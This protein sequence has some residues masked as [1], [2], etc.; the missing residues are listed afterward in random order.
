[1]DPDD[2]VDFD[3]ARIKGNMVENIKKYESQFIHGVPQHA[4]ISIILDVNGKT[5]TCMDGTTRAKAKQRAK[6]VKPSQKILV[7]TYHHVVEGFNRD[8]WDDFQDQANDHDGAQPAT[9]EDMQS[10]ILERVESGRLQ[11]V[12]QQLLGSSYPDTS[13]AEGLKTFA[14]QGGIWAK[15]TLFKN[16]SRTGL[17]FENRIF[18]AICE[19]ASGPTKM[20]TRTTEEALQFYSNY[21]DTNYVNTSGNV[22][23]VSAGEKVAEVVQSA[24]I[25][26]WSVG[27]L[28][29]YAANLGD[30]DGTFTLLLN[31]T[32]TE[33]KGLDAKKLDRKREE[34]TKVFLTRRKL[35]KD[36][37]LK[38]RVV[39]CP[40][41]PEDRGL[42][43]IMHDETKGVS[44]SFSKRKGMAKEQIALAI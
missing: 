29:T 41:C 24:R 1:M 35:F 33:L 32:T 42:I 43:K 10:R 15:D 16:S 5:A 9:D 36:S 8:D 30:E 38:V 12:L 2:I 25:P 4:P 13:T 39:A 17:W 20:I 14:E 7:S 31:Y 40:Q 19:K 22:R 18:K 23:V 11:Q 3:Q 21:G 37:G 6:K 27:S 44:F 34:D 26:N 28:C